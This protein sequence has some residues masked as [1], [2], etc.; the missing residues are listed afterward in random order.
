MFTHGGEIKKSKNATISY[1]RHTVS[2]KHDINNDKYVV[3]RKKY[4]TIKKIPKVILLGSL[5]KFLQNF[6]HPRNHYPSNY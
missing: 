5:W 4:N 3:I 2:S 6:F 1:F